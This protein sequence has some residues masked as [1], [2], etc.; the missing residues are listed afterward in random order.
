SRRI[1]CPEEASMSARW[2]YAHG[3]ATHGPLTTEEM[4]ARAERSEI[5]PTDPVWPE[6]SDRADATA[7]EAFLRIPVL[8][9]EV[10]AEEPPKQAEPREELPDWL[11]DV[12]KLERHGPLPEPELNREA[13][14]WLEDLR[15]WVALDYYANTIPWDPSLGEPPVPAPPPAP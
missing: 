6:G 2:F 7:A 4:Q 1:G 5:S 8:V 14:A 12:R 15:L 13:P 10:I 3:D 11:E 9:P